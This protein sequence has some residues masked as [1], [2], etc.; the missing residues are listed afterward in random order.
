[1]KI[2]PTTQ[3]PQMERSQNNTKSNYMPSKGTLIR[4]AAVTIALIGAYKLANWAAEPL[5]FQDA[6]CYG[7]STHSWDSPVMTNG[8]Y[9]YQTAQNKAN[10]FA[11]S[12]QENAAN[13]YAS[14]LENAQALR[15]TVS[16][17]ANYA[18]ER[19][20]EAATK[21]YNAIFVRPEPTL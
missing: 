12:A 16:S 14:T 8:A 1:M 15:E 21:L 5:E 10:E 3:A 6:K 13:M 4:A 19:T 2:Q 17:N 18:I 7:N 11:S 9:V 20:Q